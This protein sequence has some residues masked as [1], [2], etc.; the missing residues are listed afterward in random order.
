M[1]MLILTTLFITGASAFVYA[2]MTYQKPLEVTTG[3]GST[4][5]TRASFSLTTTLILALLAFFNLGIFMFLRG[6]HRHIRN[7]SGRRGSLPTSLRSTPFGDPWEES[8]R[9]DE[10]SSTT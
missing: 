2:G 6:A 1:G 7:S 9:K 4:A 3:S 5:P 10:E 8:P